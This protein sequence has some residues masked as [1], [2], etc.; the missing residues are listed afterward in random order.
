[1]NLTSKERALLVLDKSFCHIKSAFNDAHDWTYFFNELSCYCVDYHV[2]NK[3]CEREKERESDANEEDE[4]SETDEDTD[5]EI[6]TEADGRFC[7]ARTV[8]DSCSTK[9]KTFQST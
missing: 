5:S 3:A 7:H 1:M 6:D 8:P 9:K 2:Q 4:T